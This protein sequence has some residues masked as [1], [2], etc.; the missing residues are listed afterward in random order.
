MESRL[1]YE[2]DKTYLNKVNWIVP[3]KDSQ[4]EWSYL[5]PET[6]TENDIEK[7]FNSEFSFKKFYFVTSR[8]KS[9]EVQQTEV[10]IEIKALYGKTK[11][12][13]WDENFES[14]VEFDNEVY[15]KGKASR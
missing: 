8:K 3:K 15:R 9:K 14:V 12:R 7:I 1:I 11:F 4:S 13:I 6:V 10:N 2:S 5:N